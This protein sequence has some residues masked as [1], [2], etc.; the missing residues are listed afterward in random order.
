MTL[1]STVE[2]KPSHAI[3]YALMFGPFFSMFD[4]GL[5]NVGLPVIARDFTASMQAVQWTASAYL[6]TMAALLPIFG[7]IA[8]RV[9]RGRIYNLGFATISVFTLLCGFAPSLPILILSRVLQAVGGAMV[10]ANGMAI[11]T[12]SYPPSERGRNLGM[13]ASMMAIGSIAGPSIGGLV[14]GAWGWRAAFYLTFAVSFVA[15]AT[16]FFTIPKNRK[17]GVQ[18]PRFDLLG[19]LLLVISIFTFVYGFSGL[20]GK[21]GDRTSAYLALAV[22]VLAFPTLLAVER[23]RPRPVLDTSLFKNAIFSSSLGASLIS[24]ATMYSPTVLVPFYL[25]GTLGLSPTISGLYLLAF[26]IAMAALILNGSALTFFGL[27]GPDSPQ[28]LILVPLFAMGLGLGL[29]Q[30]PN[31]SAA[32]GSIPKEKLGTG[33]GVVQLVKNLGMVI[34][35]SFST[36]AFS[37]LMDGRPITDAAAYL[38]SARWV[39]WGAALL[40]FLGAYI[41]SL[42]GKSRGAGRL[43]GLRVDP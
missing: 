6:L 27:V 29:F 33:N 32:M 3:L 35:I 10:M 14:I 31:N 28:W 23:R 30:S 12:E 39:Y 1:P 42:R 16:T 22:F 8:D 19:S 13:L 34:G 17:V 11:A 40:S 7:S 26:P 37:S 41:A 9:G 20:G 25:Q 36:L 4:S 2:R 38:S 15:F 21:S 24:F 18:M 43:T 5:V